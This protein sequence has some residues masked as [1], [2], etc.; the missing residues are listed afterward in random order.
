MLVPNLSVWISMF[1]RD[2]T[3]STLVRSAKLRKASRRGLPARVSVAISLEL[4]R[5]RR[6]GDL[7]LLADAAQ[8]LVDTRPRLDADNQQVD[9]VR[10]AVTD[11]LAP[12]LDRTAEPDVRQVIPERRSQDGED[13]RARRPAEEIDDGTAEHDRREQLRR[14]RRASP[15]MRRSI[16]R[17]RACA[18][19]G[20]CPSAIWARSRGTRFASS[21]A[22][23]ADQRDRL[24]CPRRVGAIC[25]SR[26]CANCGSSETR[27]LRPSRRRS[28]RK[29]HRASRR[30]C[31][32][33][34]S[35]RSSPCGR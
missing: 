14:S 26:R 5:Q 18:R 8:R 27:R 7:Q 29:M 1:T 11:L 12:R 10:Q 33:M 32:S 19:S 24:A 3:S 23:V 20:P 30:S 15:A 35:S 34:A 31:E 2:R 4:R 6:V 28:T 21:A 16:R 25:E 22:V 13:E 17:R 9:R